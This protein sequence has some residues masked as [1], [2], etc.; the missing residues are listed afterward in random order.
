MRK[1]THQTFASHF[2]VKILLP[3]MII[4]VGCGTTSCL[5][6]STVMNVRFSPEKVVDGL[7]QICEEVAG[8]L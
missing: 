5:S 2:G 1:F 6:L 3:S 4:E 8:I 7:E